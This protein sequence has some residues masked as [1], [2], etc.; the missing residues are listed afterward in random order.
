MLERFGKDGIPCSLITPD[1][2]ADLKHF[3]ASRPA[4][5]LSMAWDRDR[6]LTSDY[7]DGSR[8]LP[9]AFVVDAKGIILWRGELMD[10]P[11]MLQQWR[12]GKFSLETQQKLSSLLRELES[13]LRGG[14]ESDMR[15]L[16][17]AIF[18]IDP[19]NAAALRMRIFTLENAGRSLEAWELLDSQIRKV[20]ALPRLYFT[21]LDI[22]SRNGELRERFRAVL[23]TFSRHVADPAAKDMMAWNLLNG[24]PQDAEMLESAA[25]LIAGQDEAARTDGE[26]GFHRMIQAMIS[27][28]LGRVDQAEQYQKQAVAL[29]HRAG[30]VNADATAQLEYYE[31]VRELQKKIK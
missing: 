29:M 20:P 27:Y 15:R 13:Y 8:I 21:A 2:E 3:A 31:R 28:R 16:T 7:L 18:D 6:K 10:L 23:P 19:G 4:S 24:F 26:V 11:E 25:M 5:K 22:A 1:T 30:A 12:A 9:L 14:R 17:S